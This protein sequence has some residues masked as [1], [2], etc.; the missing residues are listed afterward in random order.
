MKIIPKLWFSATIV[1][2]RFTQGIQY[3]K[4]ISHVK[5]SSLYDE[6]IQ[7]CWILLCVMNNQR[8]YMRLYVFINKTLLSAVKNKLQ[9][10]SEI[11]FSCLSPGK[12]SRNQVHYCTPKRHHAPIATVRAHRDSIVYR[13]CCI[14]LSHNKLDQFPNSYKHRLLHIPA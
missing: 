10:K 1:V 12:H 13:P 5:I 6:S 2:K 9:L 8:L 3:I 7:N 4:L 11:D 14:L